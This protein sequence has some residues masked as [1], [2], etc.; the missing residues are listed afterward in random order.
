M[1][2]VADLDA[3]APVE[4]LLK[5]KDHDH[6]AD[7]FLDLLH[8]SGTPGPDLRADKVEDRNAQAVQFSGQT[9]VEVGEV[10]QDGGVRLAPR[11]FGNQM[12]KAAADSGQV[13]DHLYQP[14][15]SDL[16]GMDQ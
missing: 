12:L 8:A 11:C 4:L 5:G 16:M 15:N 2:N 6:L 14:D 7:I 10:N 13:R 1:A 9:Q 3:V